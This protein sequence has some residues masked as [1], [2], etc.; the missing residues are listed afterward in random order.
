MVLV[1]IFQ[2]ASNTEKSNNAN[3]AQVT[4]LTKIVSTNEA[5]DKLTE[6]AMN[7]STMMRAISTVIICCGSL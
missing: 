4:V 1:F 7:K 3:I 5:E 2:N 6:P